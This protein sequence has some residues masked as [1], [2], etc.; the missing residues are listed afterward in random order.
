MTKALAHRDETIR[1]RLSFTRAA[2]AWYRYDCP[3]VGAV[4]TALYIRD[5][6]FGKAPPPWVAIRVERSRASRDS[7]EK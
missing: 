5:S 2:K 7:H 4:I 1:V 3:D 6:A